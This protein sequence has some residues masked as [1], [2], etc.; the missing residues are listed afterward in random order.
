MVVKR[1]RTRILTFWLCDVTRRHKKYA[2]TEVI[3]TRVK[4]K[5]ISC[6]ETRFGFRLDVDNEKCRRGM[7]EIMRCNYSRKLVRIDVHSRWRCEKPKTSEAS[8]CLNATGH[9][10]IAFMMSARRLACGSWER[11]VLPH[12]MR[13]DCSRQRAAFLTQQAHKLHVLIQCKL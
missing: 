4:K 13:T 6:T 8:F 2:R 9:S 11:L 5:E 12:A 7:G 1:C 10:V 3:S